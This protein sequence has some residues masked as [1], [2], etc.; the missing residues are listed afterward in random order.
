M[1][2][3]MFSGL[4]TALM[5]FNLLM[6]V[7][8]CFAGTFIGMLPGLGPI[9]AVALMIPITYTLDP[10]SGIILMAGVY[11]G[12]VFGGSTSSILINAPGCASTLVTTFDGYPLA[13]K[14]QAG[15]AL[16]LAAY[17][18]F[19]GGTIGAIILIFT[20]PALASVSLSFQSADYFALM[21]LGLTSVAAFSGKGQVIKAMMMTVFGLM[22]ATVGNDVI[23]GA[24]RYTFGA[25]DLV[26][27]VSFLLLAMATFALAEVMMTI[28]RGQMHGS[29]Q[30]MQPVALSSMKLSRDEVKEVAPTIARSSVF[31]FVVGVLPGAGATIASFLA[32]GLERNIAPPR[33]RKM[34][35]K[36]AL[37]GLAAPESANNAA[38][39]GSFVPL[40]TLG[41]PGSG[42]TAI[43][44]G[45]LIA[46]GIQP[47][48]RLYLDHP[49]V[50]WSVIISMY[51]GNLVLLVLNL[52]L[53][54][55]I[56]RLLAIP[57]QILNPLIIFFSIIGVYLVSFNT[58]DIQ[59][60]VFITLLAVGLKLLNFPMAPMLLG[61]I[62]GGML[63]KNLSRALVVS[64]GSFDFLWQR[65]LTFSIVC[66]TV[67]ILVL[68]WLLGLVKSRLKATLPAAY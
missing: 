57:P 29:E 60:M 33:L 41:I 37:R 10:S 64:D 2:D 8:G 55:Y 66:I 31:G 18:S 44:L 30:A 52:P 21:L 35:G 59:I 48:P 61:F 45:A 20:A 42:T 1:L 67:V 23:T 56:S 38:S 32:Y 43:M 47:G 6:V 26:D 5:P 28:M 49:D 51:F 34:F 11:Y 13:Q 12:A 15:K 46:Y 14:N 62:L 65:P 24:P 58:F 16:A 4:A 40:L 7:V 53:I 19:T 68:P 25:L 17:A 39:T 50:F 22:I 9:S 27:G 63:E 3:G 54:P 36:G